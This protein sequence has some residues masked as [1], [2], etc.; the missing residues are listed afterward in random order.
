MVLNGHVFY[1]S[2]MMVFH[3]Y[4]LKY[5]C[6]MQI[7]SIQL[8]Y[9]ASSNDVISGQ[10]LE[11]RNNFITFRRKNLIQFWVLTSQCCYFHAW[12]W[13]P[14]L[15]NSVFWYSLTNS[16]ISL[17]IMMIYSIFFPVWLNRAP[18]KLS[19][20]SLVIVIFIHT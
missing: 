16:V 13:I 14:F 1:R 15:W 3:Y 7:F 18:R 4:W 19:T 6:D 12:V 2:W 20:F 11:H 9:K 8:A 10:G 5:H 17:F